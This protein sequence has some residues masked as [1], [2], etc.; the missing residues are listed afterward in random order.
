MRTSTRRLMATA[1]LAGSGL[2]LTA[3]AAL[4]APVSQAPPKTDMDTLKDKGYTCGRIGVGGYSC[5]KK[6]ERDQLCDNSGKCEAVR[7]LPTRPRGAWTTTT[8][9]TVG[10][11]R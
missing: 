6:G 7:V 2:L 9:T 10:V 8:P 11:L 3:P 4:A 1:L 5:T